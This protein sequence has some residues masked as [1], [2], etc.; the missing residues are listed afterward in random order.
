MCEDDYLAT[1]LG[2]LGQALRNSL[3]PSMIERGNRVV[4]N[5]AVR[6]SDFIRF[7]KK[8]GE[9]ESTLFALTEYVAIVSDA[10]LCGECNLDNAVSS[11]STIR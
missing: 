5:Y 2:L 7:G 10:L 3:H 4:D 6:G 1:F 11:I 8:A 9:R